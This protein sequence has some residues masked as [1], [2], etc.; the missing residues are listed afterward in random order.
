M[1]IYHRK[2]ASFFSALAFLIFVTTCTGQGIEVGNPAPVNHLVEN[3]VRVIPNNPQEVYLI[4]FVDSTTA[5][6]TQIQ[7]NNNTSQTV[8]VPYTF[9]DN[10]IS[11]D[12]TFPN[13]IQISVSIHV[14]DNNAITV[15]LQIDGTPTSNT[16]DVQTNPENCMTDATNFGLKITDS[17][18]TTITTCHPELSCSECRDFMLKNAQISYTDNTGTQMLNLQT[19]ADGLDNNSIHVDS[20]S[21][22]ACLSELDG[23]SLTCTNFPP[24][25]DVAN[26]SNYENI[27]PTSC[28][29]FTSP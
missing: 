9:S 2:L 26:P 10:I 20:S 5:R 28:N 14:N 4:T 6:V 22:D 23:N 1:Y 13:N 15:D 19:F 29:T 11:F 7:L 25:F 21:S 18:C 8:T 17:V 12:A 3:T 24:D 16:S 27:L